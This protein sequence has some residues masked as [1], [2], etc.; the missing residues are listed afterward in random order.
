MAGETGSSPHALNARLLFEALAKEPWRFGFYEALRRIECAMPDRP[1]IGTSQ[2][3][4]EDPVRFGQDPS[5]RFAPSTFSSFEPASGDRPPRLGNLFF[6]LFGPNGPLPIHLTAFAHD[7]IRNASDRTFARFADL[8]HHRMLSLF[9]RVWASAQPV[10]NF[11]RPNADRF[12]LYLGSLAGMGQPGLLA[13]DEIPDLF[14]LFMA[15]RLACQ[16]RNAEGLRCMLQEFF[17]APFGIDE[18]V[19]E[20]LD[21]PRQEHLLLGL[22][23]ATATLGRNTVLGSRSW[24]CRHRFR[25]VAGPLDLEAHERFLPGG[26]SLRTLIA[27]VRGYVGDE[28]VFEVQLVLKK[29]EVPAIQ[30]GRQG[31]LGWTSWIK[32]KEFERH[33]GDVVL[34]RLPGVA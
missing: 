30:L 29:D 5:L 3:P 25:V 22:S 1:R 28:L 14:R 12:V 8:F 13:R 24:E 6:G 9:Y 4:Q 7:R 10:T 2:R 33:A 20:W 23:P 18:F 27:V 32:G 15:G 19:G 21:I 26:S 31:R 16:T 34:T 11:D 17:E